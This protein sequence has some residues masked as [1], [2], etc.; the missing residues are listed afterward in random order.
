MVET[1][2]PLPGFFPRRL[3]AN[4]LELVERGWGPE[5]VGED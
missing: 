1:E 5:C 4:E 2:R 3:N